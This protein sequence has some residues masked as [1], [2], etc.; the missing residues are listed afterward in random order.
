MS[1]PAGSYLY[2]NAG[3]CATPA[4]GGVS[5][6]ITVMS[7]QMSNAPGTLFFRSSGM[8]S[9]NISSGANSG[10]IYMGGGTSGSV[11]L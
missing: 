8:G 6:T 10:G 4:G 11:G 7:G 2:T 3:D 9:V 5:K 1:G